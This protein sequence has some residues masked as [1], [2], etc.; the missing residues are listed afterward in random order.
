MAESEPHLVRLGSLE[1]LS[2]PGRQPSS[3]PP[4]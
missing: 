2:M 1:E 3:P 4:P